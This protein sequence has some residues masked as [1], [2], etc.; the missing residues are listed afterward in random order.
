MKYSELI[1]KRKQYKYSANICFDLENE[2]RLS[3][4]IPNVTTTEILKEYLYGIIQDKTGVHSR[5]LYGSYGTGKSHLLTV[6]CA[7]LGHINTDGEAFNLFIESIKKYDEDFGKFIVGFASDNKPY[8][9]VPVYSDFTDFDKCISYSLKKELEKKGLEIC[10]KN[11]FYEALDLISKW[12]DGEESNTRLVEV[13]KKLKVNIKVFKNEL[14]TFVPSSEKTF[15]SIFREMT[16]GATFVGETGSLVDNLNQANEVIANDYQG[17][18]FVFDEFGRYIED[19]GET[20]KVKTIQ[21]FAEYCDHSDYENHLILVS[22]KQLSLY[23]DKMKKE[24]SDEWKKIEGRFKSTSINV[25][26]DQCLS[27]IPHIIPKTKKWDA[28]KKKYERNLNTLY[29]EAWDF[30]G[31]LLPPEGGNP[32]EGGFPLHP[33]TLYALD[34]LSKKVAQNERTFFTYL[35]SDEEN[36]L[37]T[38]IE[39]LTDDKFHFVGLDLIYDYF[40][41]NIMS[42]RANDI[43][44]MY[45]KLQYALNKLGDENAD[46]VEVKILKTIAVINIISDSA[47]LAPN[48]TTLCHVIDEDDTSVSSAIDTLEKKKIIK[49]MRQYRYYDFLDSSIYDLDSMIEEKIG[50]INDEMVVNILNDEFTDFAIYPHR[51]NAMYHMNRIMIPVFAYRNELSKRTFV[52]SM[53]DY[54]D[55]IV[56][57]VLDADFSLKEYS[58]V[59]LPDRMLLLVNSNPKQIINEVKRY[60]ATKL[61]YSQREELKKDDPT[62]EKELQL[63]LEEEQA[64]L[65][66]LV[67]NWRKIKGT[68]ITVVFDGHEEKINSESELTEC[69]SQIM[70]KAYD[71][72]IIVNNDL[73]NKNKISGAIRL[74]RSKLLDNM[75]NGI[76]VMT[77]CTPLSPEHNIVRALLVNNGMYDDGIPAKLNHIHDDE[78]SGDAVQKVIQ[79]FIKQAKKAPVSI[80]E[81]YEKLKQPPYGLRDGYMPLL[82]AYELSRYDN[83]SLSFHGADRD[84]GTEEFLKAFESPEDYSLFICNWNDEQ[85]KYISNLEEIY[86]QFLYKKSKNRLKELLGAMNTHFASLSKSALTTDKYVS[87]KAKQY[88]DILS[89][90]YKDYNAFFF[91]VLPKIDSDYGTLTVQLKTIKTELEN[92]LRLQMSDVDKLIRNVF[93]MDRDESISEWLFKKYEA[94]WASKAHKVFDYHTNA[95]LEFVR[96]N[97][98]QK[99][100]SAVIQDLANVITGFGVDYWNDSKIEDF[101]EILRKVY[102]QLEGYTVKDELSDDEVKIVIQTGGEELRTT[103]FDKQRLSSNGQIMFNKMKATISNFGESI[104]QEEKMQIIA[105]LL[106]E[107]M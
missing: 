66:E 88:R 9:V 44:V 28:F 100:D 31:F 1:T 59:E 73:I 23:T 87:P 53:P 93:E 56:A 96:N 4:F 75:L 55:G 42:Y 17:I 71:K 15:S 60:I 25:K 46:S 77:G 14:K 43:Y 2:T 69:A 64:I 20:I 86:G 39:K 22:H 84:Y 89:I 26:Y 102:A 54:Y 79:K 68:D 62:V 97:S 107:I 24:L 34:R 18:V 99:E 40:E 72:T 70:V 78:I 51:Y 47:V 63:Y 83:I 85:E 12:E 11:T 82:L 50:S 37:F 10:F 21:D 16:Y 103:Q 92:V 76:D 61:L 52:R 48:R 57:F 104:S 32:F 67:S 95:F 3:G 74:S 105:R 36:S 8:L 90:S 29:E 81:L 35:A 80:N 94:D 38:Q 7:I 33:I 27:L 49:Y 6:L 13:C 45:K 106:E 101:E 30:K 58:E 98:A 91:D 19:N 41:E 65:G 5:I